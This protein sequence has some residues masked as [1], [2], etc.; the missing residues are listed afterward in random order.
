M[1]IKCKNC[2]AEINLSAF[3]IEELGIQHKIVC[4]NKCNKTYKI[5]FDIEIKNI[6]E[7]SLM[8]NKFLFNNETLELVEGNDCKDCYLLT[9][10]C[11]SAMRNKIIPECIKYNNKYIFKKVEEETFVFEGKKYKILQMPE[12]EGC[13]EKCAFFDRDCDYLIRKKSIPDCLSK[14]NDVYFV[15]V[16]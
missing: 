5:D 8:G 2:G 12:D 1:K 14:D 10:S 15:E 11:L 7:I 6:K 13:D 4:C 9:K 16:K 3:E